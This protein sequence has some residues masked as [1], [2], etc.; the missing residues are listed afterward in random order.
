MSNAQTMAAA[1]A[2]IDAAN[3]EAVSQSTWG[4]LAPEKNVTYRGGILFCKSEYN[5]GTIT[6]IASKFELDSSPWFY[7]AIY[8]FLYSFENL[9]AGAVYKLNATFRNYR[10]WGTPIKQLAL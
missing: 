1:F 10:W 6:L 9:E 3:R 8:E 5:S 4:H 2:P 7:D